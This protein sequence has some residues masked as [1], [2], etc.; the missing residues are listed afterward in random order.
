MVSGAVVMSYTMYT[1][2]LGGGGLKN[3]AVSPLFNPPP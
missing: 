2:I 1:M 3:F